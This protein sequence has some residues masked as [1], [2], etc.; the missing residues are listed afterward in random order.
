MGIATIARLYNSFGKLSVTVAL[1]GHG[2]PLE[3]N[4]EDWHV[5][6]QHDC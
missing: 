5:P 2:Q 6:L 3:L 4:E 1:T